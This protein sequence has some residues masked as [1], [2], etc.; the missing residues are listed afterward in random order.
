MEQ[1]INSIT[2][3]DDTLV[4]AWLAL[5]GKEWKKSLQD[6]DRIREMK[7]IIGGGTIPCV[8]FNKWVD[9]IKILN[10]NK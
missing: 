3:D 8:S 7:S 2:Y 9:C 5:Y 10:N 4:A 1:K 6:N